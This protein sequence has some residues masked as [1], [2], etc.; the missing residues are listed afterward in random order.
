MVR[1][2][3]YL[4]PYEQRM[5]HLVLRNIVLTLS[6][7]QAIPYSSINSKY[8][9]TFLLN[10]QNLLLRFFCAPRKNNATINNSLHISNR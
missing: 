7:Q 4:F 10:R 2:I 5:V 6:F 1:F 8:Q 3:T 9:P